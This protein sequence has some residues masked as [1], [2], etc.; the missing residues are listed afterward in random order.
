MPPLE[1]LLEFSKEFGHLLGEDIEHVVAELEDWALWWD[2]DGTL[3]FVHQDKDEA[4]PAD[5]VLKAVQD[6]AKDATSHWR[7][8]PACY[9]SGG[10]PEARLACP[11]CGGTGHND[12]PVP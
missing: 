2:R 11:A 5:K 8:C 9:G 7:S 1:A 3:I 4:V 12:D 10:G 6:M